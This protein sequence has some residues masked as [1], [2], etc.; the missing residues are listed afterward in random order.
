M[1]MLTRPDRKARPSWAV[2]VR[3]HTGKLDRFVTSTPARIASKPDCQ[4]LAAAI[5]PTVAMRAAV[6]PKTA[7][8]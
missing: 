7:R 5:L 1:D 8:R 2:Y 4:V 6:W 3:W